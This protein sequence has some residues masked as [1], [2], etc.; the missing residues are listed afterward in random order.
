MFISNGKIC[1]MI[2]NNE[3]NDENILTYIQYDDNV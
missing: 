3:K 1:F 2:K